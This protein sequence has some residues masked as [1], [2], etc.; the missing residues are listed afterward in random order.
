M[1]PA[2]FDDYLRDVFHGACRSVIGR[3]IQLKNAIRH[4][5]GMTLLRKGYDIWR[6]SKA[7]NHSDIRMTEHYAKMLS[8][9]VE[10]MYGR[11]KVKNEL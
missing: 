1:G 10:G 9:E 8:K 11:L 6:V 4:S 3:E 5:F 7:M 2:V